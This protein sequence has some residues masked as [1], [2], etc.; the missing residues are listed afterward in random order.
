MSS[1]KRSVKVEQN[2]T[3]TIEDGEVLITSVRA[4]GVEILPALGRSTIDAME[5]LCRAGGGES[6]AEIV[7][8][9]DR[10]LACAKEMFKRVQSVIAKAREPNFNKW[11][12]VIRLMRDHDGHT[13][14]DIWDVFQWANKDSF[15]SLNIRSPGK[16]RDKFPQLHAEM[17][18]KPA[19]SSQ[20]T[21]SLE[22]QKARVEAKFDT[23]SDRGW[24]S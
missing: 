9:D 4:F 16:L 8:F 14:K 11:A 20:D 23:L 13:Y 5:A 15:W 10:D 22:E 21:M 17:L 2:I 19:G 3:Y 24:A 6:P 18:K 7:K 12:D 1:L